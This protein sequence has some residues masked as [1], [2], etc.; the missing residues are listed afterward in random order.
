[1]IH[2]TTVKKK[3]EKCQQTQKTGM[4]RRTNHLRGP[5]TPHLDRNRREGHVSVKCLLGKAQ[6]MIPR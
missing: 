5:W 2:F 4:E 6:T 3:S 1:M